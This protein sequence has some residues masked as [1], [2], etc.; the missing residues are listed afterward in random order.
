MAAPEPLVVPIRHEHVMYTASL[1]CMVS[2]R[3][4][5][6]NIFFYNEVSTIVVYHYLLAVEA[7]TTSV[8]TSGHIVIRTLGLMYHLSPVA[9][10]HSSAFIFPEQYMKWKQRSDWFLR[11]PQTVLLLDK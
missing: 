11:A 6:H 8:W 1:R 3:L 2:V 7:V 5:I 9:A 10:N 4:A